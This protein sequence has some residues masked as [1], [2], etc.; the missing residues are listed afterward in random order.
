MEL[1]P[2]DWRVRLCCAAGAIAGSA[3][4]VFV[5]G[6]LIELPF[7]PAMIAFSAVCVAGLVLGQIVGRLLFCPPDRPPHA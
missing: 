4:G 1:Y 2:R 6:P 7:W 3:V 5:V